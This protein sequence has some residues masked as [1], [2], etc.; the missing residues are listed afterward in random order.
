MLTL[1]VE[2]CSVKNIIVYGNCLIMIKCSLNYD[3][4]LS[5]AYSIIQPQFDCYLE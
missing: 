4:W 3:N 1:A 5:F 2:R